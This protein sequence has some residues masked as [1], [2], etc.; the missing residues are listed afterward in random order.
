M[1]RREERREKRK[2][3]NVCEDE[4]RNKVRENNR[5][6]ICGNRREGDKRRE[7]VS[8]NAMSRWETWWSWFCGVMSMLTRFPGE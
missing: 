2:K 5:V 3:T 6:R 7:E 8:R 4:G 1:K